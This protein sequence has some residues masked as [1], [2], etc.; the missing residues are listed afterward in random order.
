MADKVAIGF[1]ADTKQAQREMRALGSAFGKLGRIATSAE[2]KFLAAGV[3]IVAVGTATVQAGKA[4]VE[5]AK[6][7]AKNGDEFARMSRVLG[8]TNKEVQQLSFLAS[9]AR[10]DFAKLG[11]GLKRLQRNMLDS[12][13]GNTRMAQAFED[14][15]I[16]T[17]GADG[18]LRNVVDVT[19]DLADRIKDMGKGADA[20]GTLM[21][22]LGRA[23]TETADVFL[24]GS[25]AFDQADAS[26]RRLGGYMSNEAMRAS[27]AYITSTV[28]L[29]VAVQGLEN[30]FAEGLIPVMTNFN[31]SVTKGIGLARALA[32]ELNDSAFDKA[33]TFFTTLAGNAAGNVFS[34][35][36]PKLA[37]A[38]KMLRLITKEEEF[39]GP[40]PPVGFVPP[41]PAGDGPG[42]ARTLRDHSAPEKL[43]G[44]KMPRFNF[45]AINDAIT[46]SILG[47]VGISDA[48]HAADTLAG[49]IDE[50]NAAEEKLA[51]DRKRRAEEQQE[52]ANLQ[53]QNAADVFGAISHFAGLAQTAV[54]DSYFG[55]SQAGK[56][57]AKVMFVVAK[58]SAL[59]QAAVNTALAITNALTVQPFPV[60]AALAVGA[61]IAGAVQ[62]GTIA[63][64]TI[65]GLADGGLAPGDLK[66]AGL[67]NH[68]VIGVRNDEMV[69]DPKGT[70]DISAMF[71]MMRREKEM[72]MMERGA[73]SGPAAVVVNLDGRR[74]SD[75]LA[76]HQTAMIEDGRDPR[77]NVRTVGAL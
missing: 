13:T 38:L 40:L 74:V 46:A 58:A 71:A 50:T 76:P 49:I 19:K 62:I 29:D 66:R 21:L 42:S 12:T 72:G 41:T 22:L 28:E 1:S 54:E 14:L 16:K 64:T 32:A 36:S 18:R 75:G 15:E 37:A 65:Q 10:V 67:N 63:A 23:G 9:G 68:T 30:S 51:A 57:A 48:E 70:A 69:V 2:G 24:Q 73:N 59:A 35:V 17:K 25:E 11:A 60:G 27:E 77:R 43:R 55:Q 6:S 61:G 56:T 8:T 26:L 4:L 7:V 45:D 53:T 31:T 52:I 20:T 47:S 34:V 33:A 39:I 44:A 5:S 3:A